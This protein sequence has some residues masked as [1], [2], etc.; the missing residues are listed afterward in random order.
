MFSTFLKLRTIQDPL[1]ALEML[2]GFTGIADD[3]RGRDCDVV[4]PATSGAYRST[5]GKILLSPDRRAHLVQLTFCPGVRF[6]STPASGNDGIQ[7][8]YLF[9]NRMV[10]KD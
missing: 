5:L 8:R 4:F 10:T 7:V 6:R 9:E 2:H 3:G 1:T